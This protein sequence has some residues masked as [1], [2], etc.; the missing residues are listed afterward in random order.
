M[1]GLELMWS[2][3]TDGAVAMQRLRSE[4]FPGSANAD[5]RCADAMLTNGD[6]VG[7]LE[8]FKKSSEMDGPFIAIKEKILA[9][10]AAALPGVE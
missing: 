9:I 3:R 5:D 6:T 2:G 7:A 4:Q 10:E 8:D 1:S